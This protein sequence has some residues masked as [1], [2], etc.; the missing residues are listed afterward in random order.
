MKFKNYHMGLQIK[1][2]I[3]H[4]IILLIFFLPISNIYSQENLK[5]G[6]TKISSKQIEIDKFDCKITPSFLI[7]EENPENIKLNFNV[8]W[9]D[10]KGS[11]IQQPDKV[12]LFIKIN[13]NIEEYCS[14]NGKKLSTSPGLF[15][16]KNIE[17]TNSISF[18]PDGA[19]SISQY[20]SIQFNDNMAPISLKV[21]N[22][23]NSPITM[24]LVAYIGKDKGNSLEIS[25]KGS[26][27]SWIIILPEVKADEGASCADLEKKY[28][29]KFEENKPKFLLSYFETKL[30]ELEYD[31]ETT[32]AQ[33][34]K[35]NSELIKYKSN[36][37]ALNS[38][39]EQITANPNYKKCDKL[40]QLIGSINSFIIDVSVIQ[41]LID[42]LDI[43]IK[44][45]TGSSGT[46][47]GEPP[48][49]AFETNNTFC[50]NT[51]K[52]LF[53][54]KYDPDLLN[55]QEPNYLR[56][57]YVKLKKLKVS[58]DSLFNIIVGSDDSPVYKRDYQ[59]FNS[60]YN[61]SIAT[62]EKLDPDIANAEQTEIEESSPLI[63][64][65]GR[66]IPYT[67]IIIPIIFILVAFGGFKLFKYFKKAKSLND[68]TK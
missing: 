41:K 21:V 30:L 61:G 32:T 43:A 6:T 19:I 11:Q 54:I 55:Y 68:K 63:S 59:N 50:E 23:L 53:N 29:L 46:G 60:N 66:S 40:P 64:T 22:Y 7:S 45:N 48:F 24:N 13:N 1:I 47:G 35:L 28:N 20:S 12:S 9:I 16:K 52:Q 51:F 18:I 31:P 49:E 17:L 8:V 3:N 5:F 34:W 67:W 26:L 57:L 65:K 4:L 37:N 27:L 39:K 42:R 10:K 62:I 44:N 25:E 58:Q 15:G 56:D 33:Q 2:N 14:S 36:V 38:L